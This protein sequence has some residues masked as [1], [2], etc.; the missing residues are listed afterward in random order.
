VPARKILLGTNWKM[1]KSRPEAMEYSRRLAAMLSSLQG[2][3]RIQTFVIPPFTSI[4]AVKGLSQNRFWVG[5]Q[6]MHWAEWGAFT[7]E[8]SAPMLRDLGVN[9]VLLGHAER[10]QYFN[11][12]DE[13]I[14]KKLHTVLQYDFRPLLCIGERKEEKDYGVEGETVS[15]QLR[16]ALKD[17]K[18]CDTS[19]LMIAYEPVW[20]IGQVGTAADVHYLSKM[21]AHIR[22]LL[23][24]ILG[25]NPGAAIPVAYG[26]SINQDNA[27][28]ILAR[29]GA[30]G[31]F[32]GRAA[33]EIPGMAQLIDICLEAAAHRV[34]LSSPPR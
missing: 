6:N 10:R 9:L 3:E 18:P 32:V 16:I 34:E 31:L 2:E 27:P 17:V 24:E 23:V 21:L 8:I 5:A 13:A 25:E 15:R 22:A 28:E 19:G 12:T 33:W 29:S 7:G 14:N 4:E 26:G 30:D 20:A 1:N 11:E